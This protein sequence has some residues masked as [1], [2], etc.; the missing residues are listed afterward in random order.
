MGRIPEP[1]RPRRRDRTS[2]ARRGAHGRHRVV[3]A[4]GLRLLLA[5]LLAAVL[6]AGIP[7][8]ASSAPRVRGVAVDVLFGETAA[9]VQRDVDKA[10]AIG[11]TTLRVAIRWEGLEPIAKGQWAGWYLQGIDALVG[12]ARARGLT[13]LLTP[14]GTPC[15][16]AT[17]PGAPEACGPTGH[18]VPGAASSAPR[19][20]AD[21]ADLVTFLLRRYGSTVAG[22][23]VWNEPNHPGFWTVPDPAGY[24]ALLRETYAAAKRVAPSVV[25]VGAALAG[26]DTTF[27]DQLYAAG[28]RG[29]YDALSV[30]AYN[31]G[32]DPS[33]L[34]DP[35]WAHA[36]WLQGLRNLRSALTAH[37][38]RAPVWVTEMGWNTST[39]RGQLWLDGV[40]TA[41]QA[42]YLRRAL[43][44]LGDPASG[45]DYPAAVFVYRLRDLGDDRADPQQNYGLQRRDFTAKPSLDAVRKAFAS[46]AALVA[47]D[48]ASG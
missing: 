42:D 16:A 1:R 5:P 13:V 36:T 48:R 6:L 34:I 47:K 19:D 41:Q 39:Q 35:R 12:R 17:A 25:V 18:G 8:V 23:E 43:A 10:A 26:A 9:H 30:H 22:L 29:S 7:P 31:D 20:P 15:W 14:A 32:R 27:L 28:I 2:S 37:G 21:Y 45:I 33:A 4:H 38:E 46:L 24:A 3:S 44:M 11:A 40:T